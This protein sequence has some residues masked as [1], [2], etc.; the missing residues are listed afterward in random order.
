MEKYLREWRL[1]AINR[2][3]YD[4]AIFVADKLLALTS[5]QHEAEREVIA[6]KTMQATI[7]MRSGWH[8]LTSIRATTIV[9]RHCSPV[10]T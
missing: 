9:R 5:M 3:Q 1:D 8:R 2:H 4:T 6:N 7:A 10:E